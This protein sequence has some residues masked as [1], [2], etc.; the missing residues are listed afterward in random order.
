MSNIED[1]KMDIFW[2]KSV[3]CPICKNNFKALNI[4]SKHIKLKSR[5]TDLMGA[6]EGIN[7]NWYDIWVC[8]KC[9]YAAFRNDYFK[10]ILKETAS[11]K[12]TKEERGALVKGANFNRERNTYLAL[13]SY[14][15]GACCYSQRKNCSDKVASLFMRA[16]WL[17]RENKS[18]SLEKDFL[19]KSVRNYKKSYEEETESSLGQIMVVYLIGEIE[20]RLG[21]YEESLKYLS[22]VFDDRDGSKNAEIRRLAHDQYYLVKDIIRKSRRPV[23][24]EI[25]KSLKGVDFLNPLNEENFIDLAENIDWKIFAKD[26]TI[27]KEGEEGDSFFIIREGKAKVV[28]EKDGEQREIVTLEKNGFF[29]EMSL[30]TGNPRVATVTTMEECELLIIR[31]E[32]FSE[33]IL[34]NPLV[35]QSISKII[36]ERKSEIESKLRKEKGTVDDRSSWNNFSLFLQIK[37]MF[38]V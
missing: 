6:Y 1:L 29:G 27:I 33:I 26:E 4:R 19:E 3:E 15:L 24:V 16:A 28:A 17:A 7:P 35:V 13:L 38:K 21:N 25:V 23:S 36:A 14:Q 34:K 30:L 32:H 9:F 37:N 22:R 20:R 8:P 18:W 5:D 31:R 10:L 12:E 2:K 11:F